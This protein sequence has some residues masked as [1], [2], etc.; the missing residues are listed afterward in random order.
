[1][2]SGLGCL[3]LV[4]EGIVLGLMQGDFALGLGVFLLQAREVVGLA[5]GVGAEGTKGCGEGFAML[6]VALLLWER[7]SRSAGLLWMKRGRRWHTSRLRI[8]SFTTLMILP[9]VSARS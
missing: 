2:Y 6:S 4:P 3:E 8:R 7:K 1:V 9:I 5:E